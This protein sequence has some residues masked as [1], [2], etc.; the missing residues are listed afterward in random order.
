MNPSGIFWEP[1]WDPRPTA[2]S[3]LPLSR[4]FNQV[5]RALIFILTG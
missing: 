5:C 2:L 1:G 4:T 3:V